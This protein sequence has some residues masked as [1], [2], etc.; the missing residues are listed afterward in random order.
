MTREISVNTNSDHTFLKVFDRAE[1]LLQLYLQHHWR[2]TCVASIPCHSAYS[3]PN[4]QYT[5]TYCSP[6]THSLSLVLRQHTD[7]FFCRLNARENMR[8]G[9]NDPE[10]RAWDSVRLP[11]IAFAH[12]AVSGQR[13]RGTEL[14][15][16]VVANSLTVRAFLHLPRLL[17]MSLMVLEIGHEQ[18]GGCIRRNV[19]L[20]CGV[21]SRS[22]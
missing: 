12:S 7:R 19:C 6:R 5:S 22:M 16:T 8:R 14:D 13:S 15:S 10:G 3:Y 17:A 1:C 21:R 11:S 4:M 20:E 9:L 2:R 18:A